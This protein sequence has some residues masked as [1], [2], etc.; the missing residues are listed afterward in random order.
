MRKARHEGAVGGTLAS[1]SRLIDEVVPGRP[2][3]ERVDLADRPGTGPIVAHGLGA[4]ALEMAGQVTAPRCQEAEQP[5]AWLRAHSSRRA[6]TGEGAESLRPHLVDEVVAAAGA[7][8]RLLG[9]GA[10]GAATLLC[11]GLGNGCAARPARA[12][13]GAAARP[14]SR[15]AHDLHYVSAVLAVL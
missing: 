1:P 3:S 11:V 14:H 2:A 7:R 8:A 10:A 5:C 13:P 15:A 6:G 9:V 12:A 4:T